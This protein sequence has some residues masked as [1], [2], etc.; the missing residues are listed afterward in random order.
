[1]FQ[2]RGKQ[3]EGGLHLVTQPPHTF[4]ED[5]SNLLCVLHHSPWAQTLSTFIGYAYAETRLQ[6]DGSTR[7]SSGCP[8]RVLPEPMLSLK[9]AGIPCSGCPVPFGDDS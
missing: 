4:M 1:M 9:T 7:G 8:T 5:H 6:K 3:M 2:V